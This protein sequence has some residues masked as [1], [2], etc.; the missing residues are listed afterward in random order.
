MMDDL[1]KDEHGVENIDAK[2]PKEQQQ[3]SSR[4]QSKPVLPE[5]HKKIRSSAWI[6]LAILGSTILITMYG[7]TMLLPAIRDIITDFD[8]SYSTS[9]WILTAYLI[10][11]AV[12]T[13][14]AGKL[15]DIYGRKKIVL[16]ILIIY[17]L[18]ISAGGFS[19]NISFL[20]VA[21]VIQ[22]IGISMFPIAFGIIRDQ[23]A[24]DKLAIG[25]GVFS[26]MFAAGSVVGLAVGGSI[27]QSFGWHATFLSIVPVA[28]ALWIII[29]RSI[30]GDNNE[31]LIGIAEKQGNSVEESDANTRSSNVDSPKPNRVGDNSSSDR[32][33]PSLDIK[34]TIALAVTIASF[35]LTLTYIGSTSASSSSNDSVYHIHI[36]VISLGLLSIGSLILFVLIERRASSPLI[37][38]SLITHKILLPANIIILIFG[39]TMFMVYQTI[40][41]LVRSPHPL[42]FG[43]DAIASA[44]IQLP[45]MIIFLIFAP[46]SGFIVSKIGN[47]K[48]TVVGTIIMTIGFFS[49]FIFHSTES[50]V[51]IN[52]AIVASGISLIQ[53]GAFN[54]TMEYTPMQF[55]GV[56]LGMSVVLVLIGSSIGPAI[57]AIYMQTYQQEVAKGVSN[58][59]TFFPSPISYNMIFLTAAL[60]ST[61]SIALV[62]VLRRRMILTMMTTKP[63]SN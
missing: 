47:L 43:G 38:L 4:F 3:R 10:A 22:G 20:L 29:N 14:I 28:I 8:I 27:I 9:S 57:A 58:T 2:T 54:I 33:R 12:A 37:E 55:S 63:Q 45:F 32:R 16:I 31:R 49:L 60:V 18:G 39:M 15:S 23:L 62:I 40:P 46:S 13:P 7:E 30:H 36:T 35:L 51:A 56:S 26:S 50:M 44:M 61:I 21:R 1:K 11:G 6:T 53:V 42:G 19:T 25:I 48:P 41:I 24:K 34:G 52:L 59:G 17:I 5:G